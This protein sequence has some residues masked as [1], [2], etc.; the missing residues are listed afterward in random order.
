M[1]ARQ[2]NLTSLS[3]CVESQVRWD[4]ASL[5]L[6]GVAAAYLLCAKQIL[7][8]LLTE[9][10]TTTPESANLASSS[11]SQMTSTATYSELPSEEV[12]LC[13]THSTASGMP[14]K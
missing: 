1:I 14:D 7:S 8:S 11:G 13:W 9:C 10:L 4:L 3:I 6:D 2:P 5:A 12:P